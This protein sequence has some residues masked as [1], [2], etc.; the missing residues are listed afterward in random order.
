[1]T[2]PATIRDVPIDVEALGTAQAWY[3]VAVHSQID[4]PLQTVDFSEGQEVR[5]G[6][7]LAVIDPRPAQAALDQV[8]AKKG[9]DQAQLIA[10]AKDLT[11]FTSLGGR[12]F[13]TQQNIDQQQAKVD[14]LKATIV[15]DDA[16]IEAAEVTLGYATIKAPIDG[17]IGFRQVDPGNIVHPGDANPITILM[18]TRPTDV[19]FT[20]PQRSLSDIRAAMRRGDVPATAY[21]QN[22][23]AKIADGKLRLIDNQIDP[24]TGTVRLKATFANQNDELWPGE[25]VRIRIEIARRGNAVTVPPVALQRGPQG[26]HVF[27]VNADDT[28]DLRPVEA[29]PINAST[30]IVGHGL[31]AGERVVVNGFNHLEAGV[32][33]QQVAG[34]PA[35]AGGT[36]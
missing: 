34:A 27:V 19:V 31:S 25:F 24:T 7:T 13:D 6:D 4:G 10:A 26:F 18:Q 23:A 3:T 9:Q 36:S 14:E 32:H 17:R 33:V 5:K 12:G 16:A 20:L 22:G 15:A 29:D 8:R 11:R 30:A 28:V 1:M 2:A 35:G 21:D